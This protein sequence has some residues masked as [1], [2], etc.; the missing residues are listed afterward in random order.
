M[1]EVACQP[2]RHGWRCRVTVGSGDNAT[3]HEVDL[4]QDDLE[5]LQP[6]A[7]DPAE[8]V[9]ASFDFL[10]EREPASSILRAFALP[11][12]GRY[13]PEYPAEI[14]QRLNR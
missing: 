3:R 5:R 14:R 4:T 8:L 7:G 11:E 2:T 9:R 1:V 6:G 10:L 12:I 13:F